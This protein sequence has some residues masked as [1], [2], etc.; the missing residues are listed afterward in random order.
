MAK[1]LGL[2][3]R[4][5]PPNEKITEDDIEIIKELYLKGVSVEEIAGCLEVSRRTVIVYLKAMGLYKPRK[6]EL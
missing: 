1:V 3:R 2:P 4:R 5:R 6:N